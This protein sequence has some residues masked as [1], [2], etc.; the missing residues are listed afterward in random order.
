MRGRRFGA[1]RGRMCRWTSEFD[2]VLRLAWAAGG[3]RAAQRAIGEFQPTWTVYSIRKRAA[4]LSLCKRPPA[5]MVR[6]CCQQNVLGN[7]QCLLA[8][9]AER[10]GRSVGGF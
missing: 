1:P 8:L 2:E 7:R 4:A 3:L 9:I 5:S 6:S 10:L